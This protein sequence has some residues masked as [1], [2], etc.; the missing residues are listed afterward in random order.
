MRSLRD[1]GLFYRE[2]VTNSQYEIPVTL[3]NN[4]TFFFV[5]Q[6]SP[7]F[8]LTPPGISIKPA[9]AHPWINPQGFVIGHESIANWNQHVSIGKV[10]KD[11]IQEFSIRPP[12]SK[13][14]PP[15]LPPHPTMH[16]GSGGISLPPKSL[17]Q[18][19]GSPAPPPRIDF[20][21]LDLKTYRDID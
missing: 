3:A 11:I 5:L 16:M 7:S 2:I 8:P 6:L 4:E 9:L 17:E 10:I 1:H 12:K 20:P 18:R 19:M 14:G 21:S 13:Q 15:P